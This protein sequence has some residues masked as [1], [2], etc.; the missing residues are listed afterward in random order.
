MVFMENVVFISDG[1]AGDRAALC[2]P[3]SNLDLGGKYIR[4]FL[5]DILWA[6]WEEFWKDVDKRTNGDYILVTNGDMVEGDH[7]RSKS[8][9][10]LNINDQLGIAKSILLPK[11]KAAKAYYAI[12]GTRAH[13]GES[14]EVEETLA[15][16]L[17]AIRD[18]QNAIHCRPSL[19][20]KVEDVL[21]NVSH[22]IGISGS[23]QYESSALMQE[24]TRVFVEC[25]RWK[26]QLPDVIVRSHRHRHLALPI[27]TEKGKTT[28]FTLP[29]W[30]LKT[31]YV[32]HVAGGGVAT[33]QIGGSVVCVDGDKYQDHHFVKHVEQDQVEEYENVKT[34]KY[35]AFT[36]GQPMAGGNRKRVPGRTERKK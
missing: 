24:A 5:Q 33:P 16:E 10:S 3:E 23:T 20:L 31:S 8:A 22:Y 6:W 25:G 13:S 2:P 36:N 32:Y 29:A 28:I 27:T 7:H 4:S 35:I 14:A 11:V 1:H 30:Q 19:N 18:S 15:R 21:F 34:E 26:R 9:L 17:G 12:R